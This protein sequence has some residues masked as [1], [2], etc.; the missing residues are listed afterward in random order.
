MK[1]LIKTTIISAAWVL[2]VACAVP[3]YAFEHGEGRGSGM[4]EGE[5][6]GMREGKGGMMGRMMEEIGLTTEQQE[7]MRV[8]HVENSKERKDVE[9]NMKQA[10]M[11]LKKELDKE[12]SDTA[13]INKLTTEITNLYGQKVENRVEGVLDMKK[14]LTREQFEVLQEKQKIRKEPRKM[15]RERRGERRF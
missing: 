4:R 8:F 10:R 14:V 12:T 6:P 7:Q 2:V 15:G 11:K 13:I 1:R 3:V 9:A 5:G